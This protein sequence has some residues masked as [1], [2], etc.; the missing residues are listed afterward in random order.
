MWRLLI[1]MPVC[2]TRHVGQLILRLPPGEHPLPEGL[3]QLRDC[4]SLADPPLPGREVVQAPLKFAQ[5]QGANVRRVTSSS[6]FAA[7]PRWRADGRGCAGGRVTVAGRGA[8]D[9]DAQVWLGVAPGAR[10]LRFAGERVEADRPPCGFESAQR[11]R[12]LGLG[13]GQHR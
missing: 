8:F 10:D 2:P 13:R 6:G 11:C 7:T 5:L 12:P 1:A 9:L 3:A 4:P